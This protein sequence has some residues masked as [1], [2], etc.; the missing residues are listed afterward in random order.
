MENYMQFVPSLSSTLNAVLVPTDSNTSEIDEFSN[1]TYS[2]LTNP[3]TSTIALP[4]STSYSHTKERRTIE[5]STETLLDLLHTT[6]DGRCIFADARLN[7]GNLSDEAQNSLTKLIINHLFQEQNRGSDIYFHKIADLIVEIFPKEIKSIYFIPARHEG[8]SQTH[9]KGKL[10]ERWK[11]V[12]RKLRSL[13]AID[14]ER[15][16]KENIN[17]PT[18]SHQ[19][20]S[21]EVECTKLWLK[22]DGLSA[23]FDDILINKWILT[24]EIRKAD[25]FGP[26]SRNL[27]SVFEL[28]PL[29]CSPKGYLLVAEDFKIGYPDTIQ[30][31]EDWNVFIKTWSDFTKLLVTLR[32]GSIK[33]KHARSLLMQL[34]ASDVNGNFMISEIIKLLLLPYLIPT[35]TQIKNSSANT[36]NKTKFWKPSLEESAAAFIC[37]VT[38]LIELNEEILKRR[39]KYS[40]F[41]ATIQPYL[42]LVGNDIYS[43]N[44]CYVR[45]N[46]QLWAFECPLKALDACFK[47]YFALNCAY[48][49][50]CYETWMI[51]QLLVHKIKTPF[52]KPTAI[53]NTILNK[54]S[55]V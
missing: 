22:N 49:K 44:T 54:F 33:D 7:N 11:N 13:G 2:T 52:D 46:E 42:I 19:S 47:I 26:C 53:I 1:K 3:S 28:W 4:S 18:S 36:S 10:V 48:S 20:F 43:I 30:L 31:F 15:G 37:H 16:K 32:R 51:I 29:I 50:E 38:N 27:S 24:Y 12:A 9:S 14:Y 34:D 39:K 25:V 45:V 6:N 55:N 8:T 35:K 21:E 5:W 41:G 40:Q 17:I 23:P